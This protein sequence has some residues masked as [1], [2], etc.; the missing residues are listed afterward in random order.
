MNN[1]KAI[2]YD[3]DN[4]IYPQIAD[5][6]QRIDYCIKNFS[7]PNAED[8]K[9]VW[10][11]EWLKNGP[12]KRDSVDKVIQKCS[13]KVNKKKLLAVYRRYNSILFLRKDVREML[14][15][16]KSKGIRQFL[17][18]NGY[19]QTQ[20]NKIH[21]LGIKNFFDEIIVAI[22]RYSKPSGYWFKKLCSKYNLDPDECLSVGD[23]YTVDGLASVSVGIKFLYIDDGPIKEDIPTHIAH[24]KKLNDIE[25]C[26]NY[27]YK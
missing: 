1:I 21:S 6:V 3:L 27:A 2:F 14:L 24:I 11:N 26:L 23:C 9:R 25:E 20:I 13:L 5:V 7:L 18:T 10:V 8:I 4:T 16:I 22:D 15:R 17:V 12:L 19:P